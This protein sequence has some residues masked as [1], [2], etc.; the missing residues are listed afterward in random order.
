MGGISI[1]PTTNRKKSAGKNKSGKH[2][3]AKINQEQISGQK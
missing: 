2:L 3:R 1:G